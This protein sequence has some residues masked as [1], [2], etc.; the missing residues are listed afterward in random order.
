MRS[1]SNRITVAALVCVVTLPAR[2]AYAWGDEGHRTIA[3]I[4]EHFLSPA[5]KAN[6]DQLL[7]GPALPGHPED[8]AEVPGTIA[9]RATWADRYRDSDRRKTPDSRYTLTSQWHFVDTEVDAPD[10]DAACF[11][12]PVPAAGPF[13]GRPDNCVVDKIKQFRDQLAD[14]AAS[15]D[16]KVVALEFL[17]HFVGDVHQ[18]LHASDHHDRGGNQIKI[19]Y[20]ATTAAGTA[21]KSSNLH[22][23]WD[24]VTVSRLGSTPELIAGSLVAAVP[25]HPRGIWT[26][27]DPA[28]WAQEA[29]AVAKAKAY[30]LPKA[31]STDKTVTLSKT[32][33]TAA[34]GAARKQLQLAGYRLAMLLNA[35]L[36]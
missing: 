10:I 24:T 26:E 3:L 2:P 1:G 13:P 35:A 31:A 22:S 6:V 33:A 28:Q 7:S 36:P 18:P 16:D 15:H 27:S 32:Y 5:T 17:L 11:G 9:D 19:K 12:H 4:A 23:Y 20:S 21:S 34:T 14:P 30:K 8:K 25:K 29:F